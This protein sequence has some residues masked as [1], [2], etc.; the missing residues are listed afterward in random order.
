MLTFWQ[1]TVHPRGDIGLFC[2]PYPQQIQQSDA[3]LLRK[4]CSNLKDKW[5]QGQQLLKK[6]HVL[7]C[8][9]TR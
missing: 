9:E 2:S 6:Y 8:P 5:T 4:I 1:D 3:F 7:M